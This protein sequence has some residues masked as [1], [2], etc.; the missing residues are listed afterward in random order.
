MNRREI[1]ES[2]DIMRGIY[3]CVNVALEESEGDSQ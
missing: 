1:E 3:K 2:M